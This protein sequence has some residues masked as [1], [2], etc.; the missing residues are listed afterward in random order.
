[1]AGYTVGVD[2]GGTK[3]LA[4]VV[5][6][7]DSVLAR[8]KANTPGDSADSMMNAVKEAIR[9]AVA[10]A[11][12][13]MAEVDAIGL[14][15]PGV[16][17]A[18][19]E[20]I[21]APNCPLSQVP[22]AD[23]IASEFGLPA[24]VGN[25]VNVGTLGEKT[26]GAAR[27]YHDVFG[28]F[29]GT[30]IGGG[31]VI[32]GKVVIGAHALG[33]EI[34]HIIVNYEAALRGDEGGG[35]FEYYASRLG[36]ERAIRE[37]IAAGRPSMVGEQLGDDERIR[38][39]LLKKALAAGDEVVTEAMTAAARLLGLGTVTV[40]HLVDPEAIV[41]GGGVIEAT[42][43]FMLPLIEETIRQHVAPGNGQPI[44]IVRSALGDDAVLLGAAALARVL[45]EPAAADEAYPK[46]TASEFGAAQVNG[47]G[48]D[49]DFVVLANGNLTKRK[50]KLS[51][52]VHGTAHEVSV[53][54]LKFVCQDKPETLVVGTGHHG[55]LSL[56]RDAELWL[57]K[58]SIE[59]VLLPTPEAAV[60]FNRAVGRKAL[61]LHVDC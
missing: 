8:A 5:A 4:A 52:Q 54:E 61:L 19:G 55:Q 23:I 37:A 42:G 29:V 26:F 46:V 18:A 17:G 60:A 1:M 35:E 2:V 10:K 14:G 21:W 24:A 27:D 16:V 49:Y 22:V 3:I 40:I 31:L 11:E 50:K 13:E 7:D 32:D 51:R 58:K 30:G 53:D 15:V 39:G 25:D 38:S 44:R 56:S 9:Q 41:F 20:C 47:I 45:V 36:I 12:L 43:D 57:A 34:G 28:I 59:C 6:Q 48:L 33:A